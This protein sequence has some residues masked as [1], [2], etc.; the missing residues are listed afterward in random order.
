MDISKEGYSE[1]YA[2]LLKVYEGNRKTWGF[3]ITILSYIPFVMVRQCNDNS[4]ED[5]ME[6]LGK[7]EVSEENK[8]VWIKLQTSG[9]HSG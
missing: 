4:H 9:T 2:D 7:Y 5:W 3:L 8:K 1:D 6:I